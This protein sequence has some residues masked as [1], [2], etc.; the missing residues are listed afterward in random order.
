MVE[1]PREGIDRA[2]S[3]GQTEERFLPKIPIN[4]SARGSQ[5]MAWREN[6]LRPPGSGHNN[7][8]FVSN[9]AKLSEVSLVL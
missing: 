4:L 1:S 5:S 3:K 2:F 6:S 8:R 9:E 7:G